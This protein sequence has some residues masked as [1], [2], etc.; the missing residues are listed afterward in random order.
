MKLIG[1]LS[2]PFVRKI[3]IVLALK[4]L[5]FDMVIDA[6]S[7]PGSR[8]TESNPIG[9]IPVL[10]TDGGEAVYDSRVIV[11]YLEA[12]SPSPA[13][14]PSEP[15]AR[16]AVKRWEALADGILD[17]GVAIMSERRREN[18]AEQSPAWIEKQQGKIHRALA[19]AAAQL[20]GKTW[21]H[22]DV[23]SLADIA[24]GVALGYLDFRF[25]E[26]GWHSSYPN[27]DQFQQRLESRTEF[28]ETK[29]PAP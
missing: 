13:L 22:G 4:G 16:V 5:P 28:E 29:P 17:A 6:P 7:D 26:T 8:V 21:C 20:E 1:S 27:L 18:P 23:M 24:L 19:V 10:L 9:K 2:S 11:D 25:P 12:L 14:M 15:M 3:R